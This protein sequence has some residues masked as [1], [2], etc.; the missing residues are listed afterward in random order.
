MLNTTSTWLEWLLQFVITFKQRVSHRYFSFT[1]AKS[2]PILL[3]EPPPSPQGRTR[4][5]LR[6]TLL[7]CL[8]SGVVVGRG[9]WTPPSRY[10]V[11]HF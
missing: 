8:S 11:A 6:Y 2:V 10:R 4:E 7:D 3:S 1:F 5:P 9:P